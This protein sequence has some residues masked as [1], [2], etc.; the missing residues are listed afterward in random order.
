MH[1][2]KEVKP[3]IVDISLVNNSNL[4]HIFVAS[5]LSGV[6]NVLYQLYTKRMQSVDNT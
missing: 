3:V 4:L 6:I 5:L 1:E 2:N